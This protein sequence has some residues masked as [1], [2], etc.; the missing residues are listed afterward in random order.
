[1]ST[2]V[3]KLNIFF[4]TQ[5]D[6]LKIKNK[7][8]SSLFGILIFCFS[9]HLLF[10]YIG[11][12]SFFNRRPCS[13][14]LSAQSQR[15]SVA[16]NYYKND[17]NFLE[18]RIQRYISGTGI[19]GLEF[20]IIYYSAAILYKLFGFNEFYLRLIDL[21]IVLFGF[22][23]F[24]RLSYYYIKSYILTVFI[25][26]SAIIS[27]VLLFYS[28][29]FLPDAPSLGLVLASWFYFFRHLQTNKNKYLYLFILF[30]TV[31]TLLKAIA[32]MFFL[33]IISLMILDF[34][35]FFKGNNKVYLFEK[36]KKTFLYIF[37][38]LV[39]VFSWY[40]YA[41]YITIKYNNKSFALSP[42][43]ADSLDALKVVWQAVK[44]YWG[45]QYYAKETYI[46]FICSIITIILSFKLIDRLLF[47][48]MFLY[49]IGSIGYIYFFSWQF[50]DHD[51]YVIAILPTVFFT[52]LTFGEVFIKLTKKY[53]RP[54]II[55]LIVILFFNMREALVNCKRNYF[56]R[57]FYSVYFQ[58]KDFRPYENI[59]PV[60]RLKGIKRTD[61]TISAFDDTYCASLYLMDQIGVNVDETTLP[62]TVNQWIE[63]PNM[64]YLVLSDSA[65]FNKLFHKN[66]SDKIIINFRGL[67]V[68]KLR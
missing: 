7:I 52:L 24:Y 68:Y 43:I 66:F 50:K 55:I 41:H 21:I 64:K 54:I 53:F 39:L 57:Y 44:N 30:G 3:N 36:K 16:L 48:I 18:P 2:I 63:N 34:L 49:I 22:Y 37:L 8:A 19:T 14:H 12:Y 56:E 10:S 31:A 61:K 42:V 35:K 15:A 40:Y 27:P 60:L 9:L 25:V 46:L 65:K 38:A 1:M 29:N 23:L 58:G 47:S 5:I 28:P 6:K 26:G 4:D 20:P 45:Y 33:V 67:I 62:E 51:Y 13:I 59:E 17:M 11:V 32:I